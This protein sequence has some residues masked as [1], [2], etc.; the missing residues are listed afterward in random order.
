MRGDEQGRNLRSFA[1]GNGGRKGEKLQVRKREKEHFWD[2][3]P[4]QGQ[5]EADRQTRHVSQSEQ[6]FFLL[7]SM[8]GTVV[9]YLL[10]ISF[11]CPPGQQ[12]APPPV[13]ICGPGT[14]Q[15]LPPA[16]F[17]KL[18][19]FLRWIDPSPSPSCSRKTCV[20]TWKS[21]RSVL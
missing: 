14:P 12:F 4:H 8:Y 17:N 21:K 10:C 5:G 7:C 13:H 18:A 6:S 16:G 19:P 15:S 20:M 11:F 3:R 9:L 2:Q 1:L